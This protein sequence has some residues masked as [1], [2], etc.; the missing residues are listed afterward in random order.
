MVKISFSVAGA[1]KI[2]CTNVPDKN[3]L[4]EEVGDIPL[5]KLHKIY[6]QSSEDLKCLSHR[7]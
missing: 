3:A 5:A 4:W 6:L 2:D 7:F 1:R